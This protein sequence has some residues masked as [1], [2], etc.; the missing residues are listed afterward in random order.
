[1]FNNITEFYPT[2]VS[3]LDKILDGVKW[4]K[5]KYILEPS[6]GKGDIIRYVKEKASVHPYYAKNIDFDCIEIDETLRNTLKGSGLRV[7]HDDFLT[8]NSYK[9]YDMIIMNPP[10]SKGAEHLSKAL[11]I[12]EENGGD[13]ICIINADTIKNPC[14]NLR[15]QLVNRLQSAGADIKYMQHEFL[16]SE[17]STDVEIAVIKVHY[18]AKPLISNIFNGLK[19]KKYNEPGYVEVTDLTSNDPIERAVKSYEI[20]TE[21]GIKLIKEFQALEPRLA[22]DLKE[23]EKDYSGSILRLNIDGDK[24]TINEFVERMRMKYWRALFENRQITGNMTGNLKRE[25]TSKVSELKNYEFSIY[26]IKQ[27]QLEMSQNLIGGIEACIIKLFDELTY[28]YT[29]YPEMQKNIHYYNGWATNKAWI[30][31]KK[32]IIPF[33]KAVWHPYFKSYQPDNYEVIAKLSDMEKA[34]N[35]LDGG[36]TDSVDLC[37]A[38][39]EAKTT[40]QTKNIHLKY[41]DIT[42]YKKGTCHIVFTNDEL[43]KKFNIFGSQQKGWLPPSYGKKKYSDMDL[44]E[45]AVID[46]FEGESSYNKMMANPSRY[47]FDTRNVLLIESK[48]A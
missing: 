32:V 20:E 23:E 21:A 22:S 48:T 16:G 38:L 46:E 30:I 35:Y 8:F 6:S 12:Q 7:V 2:P 27:L 10:F 19:E 28:Q 47:L 11:D 25:F 33:N 31:N 45:K 24:A 18:E 17:R 43:L 9:K 3:L 26:N 37:A 1:M 4:G 36:I 5:I 40:G 44:E 29:W 15:I 34:L 39:K 14:T 42:F 13:V 41:F